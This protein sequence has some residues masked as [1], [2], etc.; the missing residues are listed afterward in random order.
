MRAVMSRSPVPG[1]RHGDA[2]VVSWSLSVKR[3][4]RQHV[5]VHRRGAAGSTRRTMNHAST[6]RSLAPILIRSPTRASH[7][8]PVQSRCS[9]SPQSITCKWPHVAERVG[10]AVV[11]ATRPTKPSRAADLDPPRRRGARRT[12]GRMDLKPPLPRTRRADP[13]P[14]RDM[15]LPD[16]IWPCP[17]QEPRA[18]RS[19]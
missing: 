12:A 14:R 15:R 4:V 18:L 8:R 16:T 3:V 2:V 13:I 7:R 19:A 10:G 6:S 9:A 17:T 11:I 1:R 5:S